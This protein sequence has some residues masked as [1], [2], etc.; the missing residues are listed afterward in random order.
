[1]SFDIEA[2]LK[3]ALLSADRSSESGGR[4][5]IVVDQRGG[6]LSI[7]LVIDNATWYFETADSSSRSASGSLIIRIR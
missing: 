6:G 7:R 3:P 4:P 5:P 1:M 2:A